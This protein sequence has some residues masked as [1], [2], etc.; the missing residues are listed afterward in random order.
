MGIAG[1]TSRDDV[2]RHVL[3]A[4]GKRYHMVLGNLLG[5]DSAV[6]AAALIGENDGAPLCGGEGCLRSTL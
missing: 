4:L 3:P 6:G 5:L 1:H 2:L